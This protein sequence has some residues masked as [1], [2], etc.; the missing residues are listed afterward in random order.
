MASSRA[1]LHPVVTVFLLL[2]MFL[3]VLVSFQLFAVVIIIEDDCSL[4]GTIN[5]LVTAHNVTAHPEVP[6]R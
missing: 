6:R 4:R 2:I 1:T 3:Y 5:T